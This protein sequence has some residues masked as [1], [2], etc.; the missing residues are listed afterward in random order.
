MI[1]EHAFC[2]ALNVQ[3]KNPGTSFKADSLPKTCFE[4]CVF[5]INT[6][7]D[8]LVSITRLKAHIVSKIDHSNQNKLP[9]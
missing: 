5:P 8:V 3:D 9:N 6:K 1:P 7:M 2:T 4:V